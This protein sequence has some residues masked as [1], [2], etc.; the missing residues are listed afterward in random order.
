MFSQGTSSSITSKEKI[1]YDIINSANLLDND[2]T[3][4]DLLHCNNFVFPVLG[5]KESLEVSKNDYEELLRGIKES[6]LKEDLKESMA[7]KQSVF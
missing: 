2:V 6:D 7:Q 1:V 4:N 3:L 5:G